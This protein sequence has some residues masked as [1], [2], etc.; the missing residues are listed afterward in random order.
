MNRNNLRLIER[1]A[2]LQSGHDAEAL[3]SLFVEDGVFEDVPFDA[4]A[5][6]HSEMKLFWTKTWSALPDFSMTLTSAFA[7]EQS[8]GAEWVMSATQKN[9]FLGLPATNKHFSLKAASIIG[10]TDGRIQSWT[11]YWSLSAFKK[12]VGLE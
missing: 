12:Q 8:G 7:G 3:A 9:A 11:D 1:A 6:G 4:V 10:F 5:R 2:K